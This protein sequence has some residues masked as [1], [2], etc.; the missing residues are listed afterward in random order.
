MSPFCARRRVESTRSIRPEQ[1]VQYNVDEIHNLKIFRVY[2]D[3]KIERRFLVR[4]E[5]YSDFN[6][7]YH[8]ISI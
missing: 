6:Q 2:E 4:N 3:I 1:T 8:S 5:F 7:F